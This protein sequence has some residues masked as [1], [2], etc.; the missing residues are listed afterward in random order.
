MCTL[1]DIDNKVVPKAWFITKGFEGAEKDFVATDSP[2]CLRKTLGLLI[3]LTVQNNWELSAINIKTTFVHSKPLT[4]DVYVIP[5]KEANTSYIWKLE[6]MHLWLVDASGNWY[7]SLK[8][9]LLSI[10]LATSKSNPSFF[11]TQKMK[12]SVVLLQFML[13][14]FYGQVH[15]TSNTKEL[16]NCF[17]IGK[18]NSMPFQHLGLNLSENSMKNIFWDQNDYISHLVKA[19][20]IDSSTSVPDKWDQPWENYLNIYSNQT[21]YKFWY[22]S[23]C[24]SNKIH[25]WK[26]FKIHIE[27]IKYVK[28]DE[29]HIKS[30]L[31]QKDNLHLVVYADASLA[32]LPDQGSQ[33]GYKIFLVNDCKQCIPLNWQSK[34]IK[35]IVQS[36]LSA[37]TLAF[38]DALDEAIELQAT[39]SQM[40]YNNQKKFLF[41]FILIIA[42]YLTP[43]IPQQMLQKNNWELILLLLKIHSSVS[44]AIF[45][46]F[47]Q[48]NNSQLSYK[49]WSIKQIV[50]IC[51]CQ[52]QVAIKWFL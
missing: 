45:T 32:N 47:Q 34:Q 11:I 35:R 41:L 15:T 36:S 48:K 1:K 10:G 12:L 42:C 51:H 23:T 16:Q 28:N 8:S 31:G 17:I 18:E 37:E 24:K 25:N 43:V 46:E 38:A 5:L 44:L 22:L 39:I 4:R 3:V 49:A 30:N 40:L 19:S 21:R 26:W 50:I 7:D 27:I 9:F 13:M 2:T 29:V 14:I 52:R 20:N 33:S 6:K